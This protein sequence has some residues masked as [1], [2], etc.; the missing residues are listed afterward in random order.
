MHL[1]FGLG[2][3]V[4]AR[5]VLD[6]PCAAEGLHRLEQGR[7]RERPHG[8]SARDTVQGSFHGF[9]SKKNEQELHLQ[10]FD[11]QMRLV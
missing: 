8:Q 10:T 2:Q 3:P 7:R 6:R 4:G 11:L 5:V 9:T 1:G